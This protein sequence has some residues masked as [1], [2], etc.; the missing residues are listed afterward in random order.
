MSL[1]C[2]KMTEIKKTKSEIFVI[3]SSE[4]RE[5]SLFSTLRIIFC[6]FSNNLFHDMFRLLFRH[7]Q[8]IILELVQS[9][10]TGDILETFVFLV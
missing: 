1:F 8:V 7:F 3:F 4:I 6:V 2:R 10:Y 5:F 9:L